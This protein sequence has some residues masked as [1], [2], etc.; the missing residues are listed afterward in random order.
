[1]WPCENDFTSTFTTS[2]PFFYCWNQQVWI[3]HLKSKD[4]LLWSQVILTKIL[5]SENWRWEMCAIWQGREKRI[6]KY[7]EI[8]WKMTVIHLNP[9]PIRRRW[10]AK[11]DIGEVRA[12]QGKANRQRFSP[13]PLPI[14]VIKRDEME[15]SGV[16]RL[17]L[18][19][20]MNRERQQLFQAGGTPWL[21]LFYRHHF[22]FS[23]ICT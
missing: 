22:L 8:Y 1:M 21:A 19:E 12:Q 20:E 7:R 23:N 15:Q 5:Q 17:K 11:W 10:E 4:W 14:S 2:L 6:M 18:S 3:V 16:E 9:K 13:L